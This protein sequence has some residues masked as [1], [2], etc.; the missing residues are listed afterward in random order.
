MGA[1]KSPVDKQ[2]HAALLLVLIACCGQ[3]LVGCQARRKQ[4]K[5]LTNLPLLEV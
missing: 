3:A 2:R 4:G 1:V 5:S